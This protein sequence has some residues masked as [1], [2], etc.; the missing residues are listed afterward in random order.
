MQRLEENEDYN[1]DEKM[2]AA[3]LS[4]AGIAKM[5]KFLEC[6]NIYTAGGISDVHHIEQ[7]LK[8]RV[9]FKRDRDY[10]IKDGEVIIVDEFT[11]RLMYGH[12]YSEGLHPEL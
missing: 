11:G 5:E 3:T 12:R 8:A 6:G 1:I 7:A 2:R 9:L 4:E 10:V